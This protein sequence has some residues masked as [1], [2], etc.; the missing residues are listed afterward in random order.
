MK[1]TKKS[2]I[3][4]QLN[5]AAIPSSS[6]DGNNKNEVN[7]PIDEILLENKENVDPDNLAQY[8]NKTL[9][10]TESLLNTTESKQL[11]HS[12]RSPLSPITLSNQ[13]YERK[14]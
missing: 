7:E 13:N 2:K 11:Q 4:A 10:I 6:K 9:S 5:T 14:F 3:K 1:Q 12:P 8:L